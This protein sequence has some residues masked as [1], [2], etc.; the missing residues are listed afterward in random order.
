[1]PGPTVRAPIAA[2]SRDANSPATPASTMKRLA[3]MHDP[4]PLRI[5]ATIA[6]STAPSRPASANTTKGAL[7][8][9]PIEQLTTHPAA[10]A[11][12]I[13]R[14]AMAA[15]KFHGVISTETPTGWRMVRMRLSPLGAVCTWPLPRTASP[16]NHRKNS[17]A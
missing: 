4:P 8:P 7:P 14:A 1:M 6:P 10:S 3:A 12:P 5:L 2:A 9:S 13:L 15:G 16:E 11:G 17:A